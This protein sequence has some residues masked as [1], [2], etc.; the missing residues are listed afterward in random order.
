MRLV[1]IGPPGSGK[2]TQAKLLVERQSLK[3]IGTGVILREAMS[4]NTETGRLA[5]PFLKKGHL[6]PDDL[7]NELVSDL[8]T[9]P[10]RPDCFVLDGYPRTLAQAVWFD[11][12]LPKLD[13]NLDAVV[14]FVV[15]DE[16]VVSR[17]CGRMSCSNPQCGAPYH[18]RSRPPKQPGIC[19]LCGSPL[20][21]RPD[22]REETIRARL[23]VF[24]QTTDA[25][26]EHYRKLGLLREISAYDPVETIYAN[27]IRAI[28]GT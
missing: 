11:Q 2:G 27:V 5:E 17:L 14:Q 21:Q 4:R 12:L 9:Q 22:D 15:D 18:L 8:F 25:L 1:L 6:V 3:Y 23:A 16:E 28:Q 24:H 13:F 19:D 10:N 26:V 20:T 7:V